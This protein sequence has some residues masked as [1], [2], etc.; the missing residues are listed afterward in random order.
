MDEKDP[1]AP[2]TPEADAGE[3]AGSFDEAPKTGTESETEAAADMETVETTDA[4]DGDAG[5]G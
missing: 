3:E 5:E 1:Q 2:E 4:S